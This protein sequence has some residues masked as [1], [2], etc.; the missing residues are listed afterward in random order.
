MRNN[1]FLQ[2]IA[3]WLTSVVLAALGGIVLSY[4]QSQGAH[5]PM[6]ALFWLAGFFLILGIIL[7]IQLLKYLTVTGPWITPNN[8]HTVIRE[9]LDKEGMGVKRMD[10]DPV[11]IFGFVATTATGTKLLVHQLA[12]SPQ[13]LQIKTYLSFT[14]KEQEAI[15]NLPANGAQSLLREIRMRLAAAKIGYNGVS[16]PLR[17]IGL[18][19][20]IPI[21]GGLTE[22][23]LFQAMN[24]TELSLGLLADTVSA[25]LQSPSA[26]ARQ[27]SQ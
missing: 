7:S 26:E 11:N 12:A 21:I 18:T 1:W 23:S 13:Y 22:F 9:V 6:L 10:P 3:V 25:P 16:L 27:I 4:F 19:K 5:W 17:S 20:T 15:S 24:E 8:A 2:G 14:E